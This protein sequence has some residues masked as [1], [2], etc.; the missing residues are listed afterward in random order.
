MAV[1][2]AHARKGYVYELT[3]LGFEQSRIR[4]KFQVKNSAYRKA[5]PQKWITAGWVYEVE[6]HKK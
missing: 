5:V 3:D 6:E 2:Y 4:V 1:I